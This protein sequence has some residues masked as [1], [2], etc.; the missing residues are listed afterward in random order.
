M[1]SEMNSLNRKKLN[2]TVYQ[3]TNFHRENPSPLCNQR[4]G[5]FFEVLLIHHAD[6]FSNSVLIRYQ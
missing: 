3:L 1:Q 6:H 5:L 2:E 4:K